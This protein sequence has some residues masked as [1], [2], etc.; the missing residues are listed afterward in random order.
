MIPRQP[1]R[2]PG[3]LLLLLLATPL[4]AQ[5]QGVDITGTVTDRDNTRVSGTVYSPAG[6][7]MTDVDIWVQ[8]DDAPA[9]RLRAKTRKTGTFLARGLARLYNERNHTG[10]A[11]RLTF[12]KPGHQSVTAVLAVPKNE[13]GT[14][15]PILWPEGSE[16]RTDEIFLE[17]YGQ[18]TDARG[19]G[20]K[21]ARIRVSGVEGDFAAET[22][23]AKDGSYS[24]LLWRAPS[25]VRI[26]VEASGATFSE[27]VALTPAERSDLV[28]LARRD[29]TLE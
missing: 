19:K 26:E 11:L 27:E 2:L 18:V 10:I 23:A 13:L 9:D 7:P 28:Q 20:A 29:F 25:V 5:Q 14:V 15:H 24:L 3:L 8:N 12:E 16:P 4:D 22:A 6:E 21:G 1:V 17:L